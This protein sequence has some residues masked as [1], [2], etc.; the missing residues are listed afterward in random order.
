VERKHLT[1]ILKMVAY[2]AGGELLRLLSPYYRRTEQEG[3]T[4]IHT[5]LAAGG[6]IQVTD[7]DLL[8]PIDP[9]SSPHKTQALAAVCEKLNLTATRLPGTNLKMRL[10]IKPEPPRSLA[11]PGACDHANGAQPDI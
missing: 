8:V 1:D 2:Q 10:A 3:R 9:L 5:A 11:F 6:D 7:A 4:L